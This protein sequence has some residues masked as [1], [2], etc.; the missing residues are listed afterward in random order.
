MAIWLTAVPLLRPW[1]GRGPAE[2]TVKG[3]GKEPRAHHHPKTALLRGMSHED[4]R[5]EPQL[6]SQSH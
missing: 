4:I 5:M 3:P 6:H 2:V 1:I